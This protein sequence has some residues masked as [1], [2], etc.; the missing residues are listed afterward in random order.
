MHSV[1]RM[2][3]APD[4][5]SPSGAE[6]HAAHMQA[7]TDALAGSVGEKILPKWPLSAPH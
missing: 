3:V 2:L 6:L 5:C 1:G 4:P 7:V